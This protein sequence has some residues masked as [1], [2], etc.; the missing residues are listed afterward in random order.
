MPS[1]KRIEKLLSEA[2][3]IKL[4]SIY[5]LIGR[6]IIKGILIKDDENIIYLNPKLFFF[7]SDIERNKVLEFVLRYEIND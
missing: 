6:L 5:S 4:D 7:G 1:R 3:G 2:T